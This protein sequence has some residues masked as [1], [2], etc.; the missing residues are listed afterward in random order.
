MCTSN[1]R[2]RTHCC[3]KSTGA[4][5]TSTIYWL[6]LLLPVAR[7]PEGFSGGAQGKRLP[8]PLLLVFDAGCEGL[9]WEASG[10]PRQGLNDLR[11][12]YV[13]AA[14]AVEGQVRLRPPHAG[15]VGSQMPA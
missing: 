10:V 1:A 15:Y 14:D 2:T 12:E 5:L 6:D 7:V 11:T 3:V 13:L 8:V 4:I 9:V